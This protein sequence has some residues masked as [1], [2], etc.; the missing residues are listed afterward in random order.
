MDNLQLIAV[1]TQRVMQRRMETAAN[2]L[3]NVTT[4]GFKADA[5]LTEMDA[6]APARSS[7]R[8]SDVRFVRDVGL[9]RDMRQ[10]PITRTGEPLDIA[11]EGNGFLTVQG[12]EGPLYTRA[13]ALTMNDAGQLTTD[14]GDPVLNAGGAPIVFDAQGERPQIG[15]D[16]AITIA[17]V[18]VGRL[19]LVSFANERGLEKV[20][21]NLWS[22]KSTAT[23]QF[24]GRVVQ[25]ALESSNVNP[26]L[27]LTRIIEI[28]RAYESAAR[29]VRSGDDLRQRAIER[30]GRV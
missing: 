14:A 24:E 18:E 1:Q 3:A 10:G 7:D 13:G 22:P 6:R 2:N 12:P 11:I 28:S 16:G 19:G 20:G 17:G 9:I 27:E 5:L 21:D 26:V 25:G 23:T 8:P 4:L 15:P 30:L 29:I